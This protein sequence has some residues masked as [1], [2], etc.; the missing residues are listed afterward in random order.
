MEKHI[1]VLLNE[2]IE[3]L[4]IRPNGIYVDL[5][6][7]RAG[8][9]Q[10][11]LK[12]LEN[13]K[14]ICFD[15]DIE[16][17]NESK[18]KLAKIN[19]NFILIKN[20]FRNLKSELEKLGINKVSGIIAD[21]GVS[22]P[23]LDDKTRGFSYSQNTNLDMRM[24]LDNKLTAAEIINNYSEI[25]IEKILYQNAD[26]KLAKLIAKAIVKSRPINTT[27]ELNELLKNTLPAKIVREKNPSKAVF[28]AFRIAVNDELGAL[29]EMLNQIPN[30]LEVNGKLAIITFHSKEDAIVKKYFQ[31]LNYH[32]PL[33]DKLPIQVNKKWRQKT[34]FP[35]ENE[36]QINKRSR[37]A[38]LRVITRLE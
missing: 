11:I 3:S 34:I 5:T 15:K 24:D 8:H 2:V 38:K 4:Q 21:L 13:G 23:Q 36:K 16:A 25:E 7:G 27:F 35:S 20:D 17:I 28:Q 26:V 29:R 9:S 18:T 14:L 33:L 10:E 12:K 6:L 37:S 22:S 32:D 30:L 31:N 19:C 1:P